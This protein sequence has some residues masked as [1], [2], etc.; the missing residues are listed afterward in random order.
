MISVLFEAHSGWRYLVIA[1][2]VVVLLRYVVALFTKNKWT[3]LDRGLGLAFPIVIDIQ[4]LL[5]LVLWLM[6]PDAWFSDRGTVTVWEHLVTMVLVLAAAHMGW[7]RIKRTE[8]DATKFRIGTISYAI[9]G[10]LLA[11]GVA[12][13][14]GVM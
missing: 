14:T 5:G 8:D 2:A 11:V 10:V 6:A 9:A 7:T 12:R 13:I 3:G 4:I 1:V